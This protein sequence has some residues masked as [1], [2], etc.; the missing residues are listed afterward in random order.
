ME[1]P[2]LNA[3]IFNGKE[4]ITEVN[5]YPFKN[6]TSPIICN[7]G[8]M[9]SVQASSFHY[10]SPRDNMGPYKELEVM[11]DGPESWSIYEEGDN[12]LYAWVPV[13]EI[14]MLIEFHGGEV[15]DTEEK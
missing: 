8:F 13:D 3:I 1:T 4:S 6:N 12:K 9:L 7:D 2:A 10:C 15:V 11:C 5:G 14:R